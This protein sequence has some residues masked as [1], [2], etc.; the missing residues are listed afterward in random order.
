[1]TYKVSYP[2]MWHPTEGTHYTQQVR[3][4][5]SEKELTKK[6]VHLSPGINYTHVDGFICLVIALGLNRD[7]RILTGRNSVILF[8]PTK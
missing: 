3:I 7:K 1:M 5:A 8:Q 4:Q 2:Q 6:G